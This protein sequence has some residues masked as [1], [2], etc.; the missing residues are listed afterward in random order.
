MKTFLSC[1]SYG[2]RPLSHRSAH[3]MA[4]GW[5]FLELGSWTLEVEFNPE[6]WP[7]RIILPRFV[8]APSP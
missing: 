6:T 8:K 4:P 3:L 1:G 5:L 2:T 7:A